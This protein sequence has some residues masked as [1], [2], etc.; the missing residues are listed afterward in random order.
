M[1]REIGKIV[2]MLALGFLVC[3]WGVVI[4]ATLHPVRSKK[5]I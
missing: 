4:V 3:G 1:G 5:F 2:D